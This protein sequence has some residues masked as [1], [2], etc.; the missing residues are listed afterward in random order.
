M[1]LPHNARLYD[2]A[3]AGRLAV[4]VCPA[5]GYVPSFPRV[6]CPRC[7]AELEWRDSPGA[8]EIVS[9]TVVHRPDR[10]FADRVPI[11]VALVALAEG[12]E[13]IAS[14]VGD[15]RLEVAIGDPVEL[16]TEDT[17][18]ELPQFRRRTP[19]QGARRVPPDLGFSAAS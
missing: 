7:L 3:A 9:Y 10:S 12:A 8:G 5:C 19:A 18:S 13:T 2:E 4:Q 14:L 15:D 1:R 11:V 16:A 6:A 17:W